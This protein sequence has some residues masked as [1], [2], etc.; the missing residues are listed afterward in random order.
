[1]QNDVQN[2]KTLMETYDTLLS[3]LRED[4][5]RSANA[6]LGRK[7]GLFDQAAQGVALRVALRA[8]RRTER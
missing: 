4:Q 1:M 6:A 3:G 7:A 2:A 8:A 5:I